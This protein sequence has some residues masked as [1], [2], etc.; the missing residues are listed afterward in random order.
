MYHASM[1][2][3]PRQSTVGVAKGY[4]S[5]VTEYSKYLGL[6]VTPKWIL[7]GHNCP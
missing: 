7:F 6:E 1:H 5:T 3:N 4:S 2:S